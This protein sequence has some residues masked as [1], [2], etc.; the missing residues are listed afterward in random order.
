MLLLYPHMPFGWSMSSS[1][2]LHSTMLLLYR[3]GTRYESKLISFTFH[4]ASTLSISAKSTILI[5]IRF[6]FHYASTLS[7]AAGPYDRKQH[8]LHSTMLLLYLISLCRSLN[9]IV[10]TFHYASTLSCIPDASGGMIWY[11]HSTMLLLYLRTCLSRISFC[12]NLHSTMLLL[13][14]PASTTFCTSICIY[15]PLCFYFIPLLQKTALSSRTDLHSTMLLLYRTIQCLYIIGFLNLHSTML[16]LYRSSSRNS[17]MAY[18]YLHSTMLLLYQE[19]RK[20]RCMEIIHLHSTMLL[21]YQCKIVGVLDE[22][23]IFQK[24]NLHSTMLLLYRIS[25]RSGG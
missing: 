19:R 1:S 18:S 24:Y 4:Y 9:I 2:Y 21:L 6:T 17:R 15:I 7:P 14:P 16:L 25:E 5:L 22:H 3:N 20:Q 10:F 8:H 13:Y 11:L 12:S 23:D